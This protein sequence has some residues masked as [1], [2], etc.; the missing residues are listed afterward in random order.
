M[1][2]INKL[3]HTRVKV[4]VGMGGIHCHTVSI[5]STQ[6]SY[7]PFTFWKPEEKPCFLY[8]LSFPGFLPNPEGVG[9]GG[10]I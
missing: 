6:A 3:F 9:D 1:T 10:R 4:G 2:M 8:F 5:S 7:D